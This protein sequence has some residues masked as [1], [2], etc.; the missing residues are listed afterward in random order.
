M[1]VLTKIDCITF[2]QK[3]LR[4]TELQQTLRDRQYLFVIT[5]K[6][7]VLNQTSDIESFYKFSSLQR[8][9]LVVTVILTTEVDCTC[10]TLVKSKP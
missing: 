3:N 1:I 7:Y 2:V 8:R 6:V 5:M 4:Q 9:E 10:K